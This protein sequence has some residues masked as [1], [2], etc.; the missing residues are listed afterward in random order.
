MSKQASKQST[1]WI[2]PRLFFG[3]KSK[4]FLMNY[5][6]KGNS[7]RRN[8]KTKLA[9]KQVTSQ[10]KILCQDNWLSHT[11]KEDTGSRKHV[12]SLKIKTFQKTQT[13]I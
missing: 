12:A 2:K 8:V 9:R 3:E 13:F 4:F 10:K 6:G 1:G 11:S 5:L 7:I